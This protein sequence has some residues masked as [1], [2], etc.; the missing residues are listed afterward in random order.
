MTWVVFSVHESKCVMS[1]KAEKWRVALGRAIEQVQQVRY[2]ERRPVEIVDMGTR[3][4]E[5]VCWVD[6]GLWQAWQGW[7]V[8]KE[9]IEES[10]R[11]GLK[12]MGLE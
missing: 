4:E 3:G 1:L 10:Q 8:S 5:L 11:E 2:R 6:R 7:S 12:V 9:E